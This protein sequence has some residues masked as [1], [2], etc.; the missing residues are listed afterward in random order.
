[1]PKEPKPTYEGLLTGPFF[2]AGTKAR[3]LQAQPRSR[4]SRERTGRVSCVKLP[5]VRARLPSRGRPRGLGPPPHGRFRP[6]SRSLLRGPRFRYA[7]DLLGRSQ[8]SP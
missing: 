4:G 3:S 7:P 2:F 6:G 1:A 5:G 8:G